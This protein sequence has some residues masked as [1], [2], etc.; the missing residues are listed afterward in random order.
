MAKKKRMIFFPAAALILLVLIFSFWVLCNSTEK[1]KTEYRQFHELLKQ[2]K[3]ESVTISGEHEIS[4]TQKGDSKEYVTDN[5]G[6]DSFCE[7]LLLLGVELHYENSAI[8]VFYLIMEFVTGVL[9][10]GV[11]IFLILKFLN[12]FEFRPVRPD[13][14]GWEMVVGMEDIK[15]E[16]LQLI[17]VMK[18]LKEY[19]KNG[20]RQ[21]RGVLLEGPPGNGKT[22]FAKA[23]AKEADINF[24][25]ARATDFESMFMSIGPAKVKKLFKSA[26]RHQPCIVFIDEFD[27]IGTRRSYSGGGIET[28]NTRIVTALLNELDGFKK[29][30]RI[31]VIAATNNR[32]ALDKAL[33]RPGR[34]DKHFRINLPNFKER[35]A[36][37]KMYGYSREKA[38]FMPITE[39]VTPEELAK[40]MQG[41]SCAEIESALNEAALAAKREKGDV[42]SREIL[43]KYCCYK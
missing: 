9:C 40:L 10:I 24:I 22:L 42:I 25:A 16:M 29:K 43:E 38:S 26:K 13:K 37:I 19:E 32:S 21:P 11:I 18:H 6:T 34:F 1:E 17:D 3:I 15:E 41:F 39:D 27:G 31:L 12:P 20:I 7:E 14:K 33:V 28:E 2:G 35:V 8:D 30:E 23:L 36:L 4:F 5:P